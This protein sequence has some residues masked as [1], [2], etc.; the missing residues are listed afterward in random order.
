MN[1]KPLELYIHI[2][3]CARK[4]NYCDFLS[5]CENDSTK[6]EYV[7]ALVR[8]IELSKEKMAG[9]VVTSI[10]IGG[11]TPSILQANLIEKIMNAVKSNCQLAENAE[12]TIECN[13][14]TVTE[15]KLNT[16]KKSGINR[17]SFGLQ[18]ANDEELSRIGRIHNY[19]Q[20]LESYEMARKAGFDNINIDIMSALPY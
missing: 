17:I 14:G 4:C 15:E 8:E 6:R 11:G 10:F 1:N 20:F 9:R 18:S 13:P 16:Y 5:M 19:S 3:F 7:N 12:I 2:P